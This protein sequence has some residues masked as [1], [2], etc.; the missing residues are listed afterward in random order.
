MP[1]ISITLEQTFVA[2]SVGIVFVA[3]TTIIMLRKRF[4]LNHGE[5]VQAV[6]VESK[7]RS[8]RGGRTSRSMASYVFHPVFKFN[9]GGQ[10]VEIEC[11]AGHTSPRYGDGDIVEIVYNKDKIQEIYIPSD[12]TPTI[13]AI[14]IIF[15]GIL[16]TVLGVYGI[17][18]NL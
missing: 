18:Y 6:V 7:R 9:V 3:I 8:S 11:G 12:K 17:Y 4:I 13:G 15:F 16:L 2:L 5:R 10:E 14:I 1:I